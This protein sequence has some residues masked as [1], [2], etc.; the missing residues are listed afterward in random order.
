MPEGAASVLYKLVG[1]GGE[2]GANKRA[3]SMVNDEEANNLG[4]K[5]NHLEH[6]DG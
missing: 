2:G 5:F 4:K 6:V 3:G 1:K